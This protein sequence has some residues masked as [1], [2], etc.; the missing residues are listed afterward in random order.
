MAGVVAVSGF[1]MLFAAS[2]LLAG[3]HV[4]AAGTAIGLLIRRHLVVLCLDPWLSDGFG[5]GWS[6]LGARGE[7]Q[8]GDEDR[9]LFLLKF[10]LH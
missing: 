1:L 3:C 4:L 8:R 7:R 6:S 2:H 10:E 5:R 9:H